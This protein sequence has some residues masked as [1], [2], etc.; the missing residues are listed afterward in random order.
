MFFF[1]FYFT[2]SEREVLIC[3]VAM[4]Y[5]LIESQIY[6]GRRWSGGVPVIYL[7][8]MFIEINS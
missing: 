3:S 4:D 7:C 5:S 2:G 8:L 6:C 1:F